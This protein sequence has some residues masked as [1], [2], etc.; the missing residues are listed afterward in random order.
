[1]CSS[2]LQGSYNAFT[3]KHGIS[4]P[5]GDTLVFALCCGQIMYAFLMSPET[6]PPS[7]QSW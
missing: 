1:M 4:I 5:H 7:Y 3:T 2:G 6:L